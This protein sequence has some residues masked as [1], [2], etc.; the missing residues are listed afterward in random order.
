MRRWMKW[1][2]LIKKVPFTWRRVLVAMEVVNFYVAKH[3]LLLI[4]WSVLI[5]HYGECLVVV[6][7]VRCALEL[8]VNYRL[9][10][11]SRNPLLKVRAKY[12]MIVDNNVANDKV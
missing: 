12:L 10:G 2:D 4:I 6:G 1:K 8:M 11:G 5:L 7:R 3:V 9:E